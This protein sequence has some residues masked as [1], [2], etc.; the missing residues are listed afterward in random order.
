VQPVKTVTAPKRKRT[1]GLRIV[2]LFALFH[3]KA[4]K[5]IFGPLRTVTT[6]A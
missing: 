3:R 1:T 6:R 2:K 4:G 5:G